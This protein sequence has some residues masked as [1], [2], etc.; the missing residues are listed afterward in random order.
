MNLDITFPLTPCSIL[1]LDIEDVTGVHVNNIQG[2][3][4]KRILDAKGRMIAKFNALSAS[5]G[6]KVNQEVVYV[7]TVESLKAK[8]GC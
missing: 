6:A 3:L 7:Q 1:S 2:E 5:T 8:E 4:Q